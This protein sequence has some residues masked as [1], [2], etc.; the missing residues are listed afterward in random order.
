MKRALL[1]GAV[2]AA[3]LIP[4]ANAA[5]WV[6]GRGPAADCYVAAA[7]DR[8]DRNSIEL[9]DLALNYDFLIRQDRSATHVNRGVLW[10][11]RNEDVRA[12]ADF[13]AS[14]ALTPEFGEAHLMRGIA[15]VELGRHREAIDALTQA[16]S[17][18][19]DR[20]ERAYY[21]RAA[22]YEEVGD[23]RA[24]YADYRR[25]ADLAPEWRPPTVELA[26][27]RVRER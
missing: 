26:R 12:L 10:M 5:V 1:A 19:P 4:S 16:M 27:F 8:H 18:N 21:Y 9:C 23:A 7:T 15:L 2:I 22:A 14:V 25:A 6:V 20:P 3:S 13:D 11:R 17:M 24:A